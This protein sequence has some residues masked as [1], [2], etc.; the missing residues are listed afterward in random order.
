M[1]QMSNLPFIIVSM[2]LLV[3]F[4]IWVIKVWFNSS[5][6]YGSNKKYKKGSNN[7]PL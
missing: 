2:V 6:S 1:P 4:S 7:W 5:K 3:F